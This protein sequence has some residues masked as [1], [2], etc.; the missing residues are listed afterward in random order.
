ME[1]GMITSDA[2]SNETEESESEREKQQNE[3]LCDTKVTPEQAVEE[4]RTTIDHFQGIIKFM[5][6]YLAEDLT[7]YR[8]IQDAQCSK[9]AFK[10]LWM[11][12]QTQDTL[13]C[14]SRNGGI[15][16]ANTLRGP[17]GILKDNIWTHHRPTS[18]AYR[19]IDT[20]AGLPMKTG[21]AS[22]NAKS[23]QSIKVQNWLYGLRLVD[24]SKSGQTEEVK[25][26]YHSLVVYCFYIDF[27][28][29]KYGTVKDGF[30]FRPFEGEVDITSLEA[31]PIRFLHQRGISVSE[32]ESMQSFVRRGRKFIDMTAVAHMNYDGATLFEP[33]EEVRA[34]RIP[35]YPV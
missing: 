7:I 20:V 10:N 11:L 16:I 15:E 24:Q 6:S 1:R 32:E 22:K 13:V 2:I 19:V 3:K 23:Q 8:A 5:E 14:P 33:K 26:R 18:Q 4:T 21:F 34:K 27:D 35:Y 9:I 30:V 17:P 25:S 31:F 29:K 28:G 12:F